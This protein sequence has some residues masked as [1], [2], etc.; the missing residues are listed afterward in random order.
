MLDSAAPRRPRSPRPWS[1]DGRRLNGTARLPAAH[2]HPRCISIHSSSSHHRRR[3]RRVV[4]RAKRRAI[5]SHARSRRVELFLGRRRAGSSRARH[6]RQRQT[7]VRRVLGSDAG[8]AS[9]RDG[10]RPRRRRPG[11]RLDGHARRTSG[12]GHVSASGGVPRVRRRSSGTRPFAVSSRSRRPVPAADVDARSDVGT[13]HAAQPS[14][15]CRQRI[16]PASQS[17]AGQ[18]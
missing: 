10:A 6:R 15:A 4:F 16:S 3:R 9:V 1:F 18:R 7:D 2:R 13:V 8:A 17:V 14:A 12:L 11:H 5:R